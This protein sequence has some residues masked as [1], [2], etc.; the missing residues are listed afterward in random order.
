MLIQIKFRT[1]IQVRQQAGGTQ[2]ALSPV[3]VARVTMPLSAA[4][5]AFRCGARHA[6]SQHGHN[7]SGSLDNHY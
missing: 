3:R 4:H 7:Q 6:S 1:P 5:R 2:V